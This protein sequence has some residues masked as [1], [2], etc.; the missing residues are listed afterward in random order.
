MMAF[1]ASK[2]EHQK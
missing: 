1:F 2:P